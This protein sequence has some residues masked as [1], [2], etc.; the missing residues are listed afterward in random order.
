MDVDITLLERLPAD[1]DRDRDARRAPLS[2]ADCADSLDCA[3]SLAMCDTTSGTVD[4]WRTL[5]VT[6]ADS[7]V[8]VTA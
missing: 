3:G 2:G 7:H 1:R 4:P 6:D 5:P 8:C